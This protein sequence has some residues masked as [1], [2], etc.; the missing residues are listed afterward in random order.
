MVRRLSL[1]LALA[2]APAYALAAPVPVRDARDLPLIDQRGTR[3]T[4][5][6]IGRPTAV[7]FIDTRCGDACPI[8]EALFARLDRALRERH[9]DARLLTVPLDPDADSALVMAGAARR[10]SA[11]APGWRWASGRP[12]D[13]RSL[14]DAFGVEHVDLR[15]HGASCYVLDRTG[16]PVRIVPL[17]AGADRELLALLRRN[18]L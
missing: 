13:V 3:F 14:L 18:P 16:R 1:A 6:A 5:R 7:I 4:L 12:A 17:Y 2:L 9:V 8:A 10:F 11:L 15:F